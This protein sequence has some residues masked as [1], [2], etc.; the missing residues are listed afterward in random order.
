[1]GLSFYQRKE[2]KDLLA[3][4]RL[5]INP[6]DEESLKRIIN[7]PARGIGTTTI[8]KLI[9]YSR[10]KVFWNIDNRFTILK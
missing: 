2:V 9:L 4:F 3:Y 5:T 8:Q 6:S 10:K 7:Y 1:M